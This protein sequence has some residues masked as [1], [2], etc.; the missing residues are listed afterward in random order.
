MAMV[1]VNYSDQGSQ[2]YIKPPFPGLKDQAVRFNDMM[3]TAMYDRDGNKIISE[4]MYLDLPAWGYHIFDVTI[5]A[6]IFKT[7]QEKT[8]TPKA[9]QTA[10]NR[11][12]L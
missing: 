4:G 11:Q 10:P 7:V 8:E 6:N 2:A 9:E 3:S 1:V 5:P 12:S